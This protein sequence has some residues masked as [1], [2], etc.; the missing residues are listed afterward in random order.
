MEDWS[1]LEV[2]FGG[3]QPISIHCPKCRGCDSVVATQKGLKPHK[4]HYCESCEYGF[5][6]IFQDPS[7][8]EYSEPKEGETWWVKI[9]DDK[10]LYSKYIEK[11]TDKIVILKPYKISA[12]KDCY[13]QGYVK[14]I[15]EDLE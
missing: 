7:R 5:D 11:I 4:T 9:G 13:E 15:E 6:V 3:Y 10:V 2:D 14:F 12:R 1:H 8:G